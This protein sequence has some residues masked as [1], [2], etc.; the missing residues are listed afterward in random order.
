VTKIQPTRRVNGIVLLDLYLAG[1]RPG[2]LNTGRY[3]TGA[4][5]STVANEAQG[6]TALIDVKQRLP[7]L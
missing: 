5:T 2:R 4:V 7:Y 3:K 6:T 1:V